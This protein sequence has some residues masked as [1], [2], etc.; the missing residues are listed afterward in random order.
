M[1]GDSFNLKRISAFSWNLVSVRYQSKKTFFFRLS[2]G[3][4]INFLNFYFIWFFFI[5]SYLAEKRI[6]TQKQNNGDGAHV[7]IFWIAKRLRNKESSFSQ[8]G[9]VLKMSLNY[10]GKFWWVFPSLRF[11]SEGR[12]RCKHFL[13]LKNVKSTLTALNYILIFYVWIEKFWPFLH[14][15]S[16]KHSFTVLNSWLAFVSTG[17]FPPFTLGHASFFAQFR[18]ADP[19]VGIDQSRILR[20][21]EGFITSLRRSIYIVN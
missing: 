14:R 10:T 18:W 12:R 2:C 8:S 20:S 3:I 9:F 13:V 21:Q 15:L 7:F 5:V 6:V 11:I 4:K 19:M 1:V 17:K 16:L